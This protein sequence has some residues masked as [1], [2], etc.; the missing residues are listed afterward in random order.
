MR[1]RDQRLP[2]A[3]FRRTALVLAAQM[4]N[5]DEL[6]RVY[7]MNRDE[8]RYRL[9]RTMVPEG[10]GDLAKVKIELERLL[11]EAPDAG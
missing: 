9:L 6:R 10:M 4:R 2:T 5:D 1:K 3:K 7:L 8:G 11:R